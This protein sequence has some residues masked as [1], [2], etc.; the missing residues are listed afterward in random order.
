MRQLFLI[1][2]FFTAANAQ[3]G[4][5]V[6]YF[7]A[8]PGSPYDNSAAFQKASDY[9]IQNP[10]VGSTLYI[11]AGTYYF[12]KPWILQNVQGGLWQFFTIKIIGPTDMQSPAIGYGTHLIYTG[13]TGF[14]IGVQFGRG[15]EIENIWL[16]GQYN[17]PWKMNNQNIGQT[18]YAAW[19]DGSVE[20]GS[21]HPY[22]GICI[23]PFCDSAYLTDGYIGMRSQYLPGTG[24]GGTSGMFIKHCTVEN[25]M[26]GAM[27][28]PNPGTQNCEDIYFDYDQ[29]QNVKVAIAIGQDQSKAIQVD[30]LKVWA[31]TYTVI[32]GLKYGQ[33]TGGGSVFCDSWN[34]ASNVNQL[35]NLRTDRFPLSARNIYAEGLYR[36]GS[37][38]SGA[39]ANFD[40]FQIDFLSGPSIPAPGYLLFGSANFHGG[41]LRYY[42]NNTGQRMNFIG[43]TKMGCSM[44][45]DM[46]LSTPLLSVGIY[47]A[48]SNYYPTPLF[49]NIL[50]YSS[51]Q[52]LKPVCDTLSLL[53]PDA[54]FIIDTLK[55]TATV[56]ITGLTN[57]V[58]IGDYLL[59][60]GNW[61]YFDRD[62]N[63]AP[64]G[65]TQMGKVISISG[66]IAMLDDVGV[67]A[68][69][70]NY[71]S[72]YISRLK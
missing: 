9:L 55:W 60:G 32:D 3:P 15:I 25:F 35:F 57:Y 46:T 71:G 30:H 39:G 17:F 51:Y 64:Y 41:C 69:S 36:I 43:T 6:L 48:S 72:I 67:N 33:G 12:S 63:P 21:Y 52:K 53:V 44:F 26:V 20:D 62:I 70:G 37:V 38:G 31:S 14:G 54:N 7:G 66:D 68:R 65:T 47:G 10:V 42:N 18:P 1:L 16:S 40:N 5:N 4:T 2:F 19:S 28:T 23:D 8:H 34:I 50:L 11:P 61:A 56:S 59:Y 49:D 29:I 13:K 58:K 24:R 45:R 22:A 27:L